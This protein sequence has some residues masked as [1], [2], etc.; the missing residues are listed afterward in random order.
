MNPPPPIPDDSAWTTPTQRSAVMDAST[1]EPPLLR[2]SADMSE[3]TGA[4]VDTPPAKNK[5]KKNNQTKS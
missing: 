5:T 3:Q 4:S 1:A 2:I